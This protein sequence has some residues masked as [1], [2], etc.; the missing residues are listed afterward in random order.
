VAKDAHSIV[1]ANDGNTPTC[2]LT[3]RILGA[4]PSTDPED[5]QEGRENREGYYQAEQAFGWVPSISSRIARTSAEAFRI[6]WD[7]VFDAVEQVVTRGLQHWVLGQ[8]DAVGVDEI[9]Y[10]KG[11]NI[12]PCLPDRSGRYPPSL[13]RQRANHRI[14]PRVLHRLWRG[15]NFQNRIRLFRHVGALSE[16]EPQKLLRGAAYPRPFP[17]GLLRFSHDSFYATNALMA[18]QVASFVQ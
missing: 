1:P 15:R 18:R 17:T 16:A 5:A 4:F 8:I 14:L 9:Q 11:T 2:A 10:R 7:K 6:P 13:S 12:S 3:L